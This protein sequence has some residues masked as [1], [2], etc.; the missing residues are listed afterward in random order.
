MSHS[1]NSVP[2]CLISRYVLIFFNSY[3]PY[4]TENSEI[5][6]CGIKTVYNAS[7]EWADKKVILFAVPGLYLILCLQWTWYSTD[8]VKALSHP[9]VKIPISPDLLK[10]MRSSRR[11]GLILLQS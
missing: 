11:E 3:V 2:R 10:T 9:G 7:K 6:Y 1:G 4:D 5:T 8:E